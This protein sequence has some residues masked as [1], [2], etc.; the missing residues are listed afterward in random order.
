MSTKVQKKYSLLRRLMVYLLSIL[1]A[2]LLATVTATQ[3]VISN[4]TGMGVDV[5]TGTRLSM[6]LQD[7]AGM[8][9]VFLP[10]IAAGYL[11]AFLVAGILCRWWPQWRVAFYIVAGAVALIAIH[12]T[13]KFALGITPVAIGRSISGL[14]VQGLAGAVGGYVFARFV[15]LKRA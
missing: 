6:T 2:Y 4:L 15:I 9:G 3:S 12:L 10:L 5:D 7:L 1:A 11:V 13:L 14:L 8:A